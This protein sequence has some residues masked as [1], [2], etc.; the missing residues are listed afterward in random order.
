MPIQVLIDGVDYTSYVP[1]QSIQITDQNNVPSTAEF[2]LADFN[3]QFTPPVPGQYVKIQ[4]T[5]F[6]STPVSGALFTGIVTSY[7]EV[8]Y[9]GMSPRLASGRINAY[10]VKCTSEEYLLNNK[11][12]KFIPAFVNQTQGEILEVIAENLMP[13]YF[14]FAHVASGDIVPYFQFDPS[15]TWTDIAKQFADGSRYRYKVI[16]KKVFFQPYGDESLGITYDETAG[17]RTFDPRTFDANTLNTPLL[18]DVTV[19]GLAEAKSHVTNVFIGDGYLSKFTLSHPIFRGDTSVLFAEDWSGGGFNT[20]LVT[21]NDPQNYFA[22]FQG[23]LNVLGGTGLGDTYIVA[24]NGLEIAGQLYLQHCQVLWTGQSRGLLGGLYTDSTLTQQVCEVGFTSVS[25]AS[26]LPMMQPMFQGQAVGPQWQAEQNHSYVLLNK[27][28]TPLQ[29]RYRQ[30]YRALNGTSYGGVSDN[31]DSVVTW[32][33]W[34]TAPS[35]PALISLVSSYTATGALSPFV[36]YAP[37]NSEN[38][39]CVINSTLLAQP[40]QAAVFTSYP[41]S[42]ALVS[43]QQTL[44]FGFQGT[45]ATITGQTQGAQSAGGPSSYNST[46]QNQ[47]NLEFYNDTIPK[48]Q[49]YIEVRFKAAGASV[50][51]VQDQVSIQQQAAIVGDDGIR[52]AILS[53]LTP[54]PR[55]SEDC[56]SAAAAKIQD[57][58]GPIYQGTYGVISGLSQGRV[59]GFWNTTAATGQDYPRPGRFL[60]V[61]SPDRAL[62]NEPFLIRRVTT[63]VNELRGEVLVFRLDFGQDTYLDRLQ[64][65]FN[66]PANVFTT[67]DAVVTPTIQEISALGTSFISDLE[68]VT[69]VSLDS[70]Q[71]VLD[72]GAIPVTGAEIRRSDQTQW[73]TGTGQNLVTTAT[74]RQVTLTRTAFRE[75]Y[76]I[77]QVNGAVSSRRT[78]IVAINVPIT[79][80]ALTGFLNMTQYGDPMLI[81]HR[82]NDLTN[83]FGVEVAASG[84]TP[85]F[86]R[87][88]RSDA[89]LVFHLNQA[90]SQFEVERNPTVRIRAYNLL[91]GFSPETV[92]TVDGV[93]GVSGGLLSPPVISNIQVNAFTNFLTWDVSYPSGVQA[94]DLYYDVQIDSTGQA[95]FQNLSV[96]GT[97]IQ[98]TSMHLDPL[99]VASTFDVRIRGVDQA[100]IGDWTLYHWPGALFVINPGGGGTG[101]DQ[102]I[103]NVSNLTASG[104]LITVA[105]QGCE[106]PCLSLWKVTFAWTNPGYTN[107]G[108]V[109]IYIKN[110][111]GQNSWRRWW[112]KSKW[113]T[114][115]SDTLLPTGES[116]DLAFVSFDTS[117][118][119][120]PI[121]TS[122]MVLSLDL[123]SCGVTGGVLGQPY[124][125]VF[126]LPGQPANGVTYPVIT[127]KRTTTFAV[128]FAGSVG[129]VGTNPT[130]TATYTVKKNGSTVGQIVINTSGVFTFTTSGG[131]PISFSSGDRLEIVSPNPQD[132]TLA[133]VAITLAGTR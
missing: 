83:F 120:N 113:E 28:A 21:V 121:P 72:L 44:G 78:T 15:K 114:Y 24:K 127:F 41:A 71:L 70:S 43:A 39:N 88:Y 131:A 52:G 133:D 6:A 67:Q 74:A 9:Q 89:D 104:D 55:T 59:I 61:T 14:S 75:T 86:R 79:P 112:T 48:A 12:A 125:V 108:G 10:R 94:S 87:D 16:Q 124:D 3:P 85:L 130:S 100:G 129:S 92:I 36:L 4:S 53:D 54:T 119:E 60:Y 35:T 95:S 110:Y 30:T 40:P 69:V 106:C 91:G 103:L 20:S 31:T 64:P 93:L 7:L 99:T 84:G 122:P 27:I 101:Y 33:I 49:T 42:G 76:F 25:G 50:A 29:A 23:S 118:N 63:S 51:R 19:V 102:C 90:A 109:T 73:G 11:P 117:G 126:T 65:R 82:P 116:I 128:D 8:T 56:E 57:A 47:S 32:E 62:V 5:T 96:S 105:A 107:F 38:L 37:V 34:D 18:N 77:R 98:V 115:F 22:I 68:N 66:Q 1:A 81:V 13:G 111:L 26:G 80:D 46:G 132:A 123:T 58:V 2:V 45:T 97:K 17:E